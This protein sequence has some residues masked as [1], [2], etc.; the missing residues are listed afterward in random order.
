VAEA[1]IP[2]PREAFQVAF[3]P[4][5]AWARSASPALYWLYY[6][7]PAPWRWPARYRYE[8]P[9]ID[10]RDAAGV[11]ATLAQWNRSQLRLNHVVHHAGVGHHR[12]NWAQARARGPVARLAAVDGASRLALAAGGTMAEGW[13][14]YA[15]ELL[16]E[17]GRLS[18]LE[19]V[20]EQHT[21]V[22]ICCRAVADLLLHAAGAPLEDVVALYERKG[23]LGAA[24]AHAEA[25]K[26]AIFPG[27]AIMYWLG[28][29][30]I[31]TARAAAAARPGA[32]FDRRD[33]HDRLLRY[34]AL[35]LPTVVRLV[36]DGVPA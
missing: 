20:A 31:H 5:P 35:P 16:E 4:I 27:M 23:R 2:M 36:A 21:R 11:R 34:G 6:R 19:Q 1:V 30:T 26:N 3:E 29:R 15:V 24:A 28:T 10:G 25:V 7:S 12:Q 22:R 9:W 8:V 33:W 13:S 17:E 14:C 18:P 32:A